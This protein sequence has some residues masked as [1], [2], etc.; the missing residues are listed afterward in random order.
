[1]A[2]P[3][4]SLVD[5]HLSAVARR[6]PGAEHVPPRLDDVTLLVNHELA[7]VERWL[8]DALERESLRNPINQAGS[9]LQRKEKP[10]IP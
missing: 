6:Q 4:P 9:R 2:M 5:A 8:T 3:S 10:K 7:S 1:M